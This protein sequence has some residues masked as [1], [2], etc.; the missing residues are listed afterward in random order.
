MH[1]FPCKE[2]ASSVPTVTDPLTAAGGNRLMILCGLWNQSRHFFP[3]MPSPQ[4]RF[5]E[6]A[7]AAVVNRERSTADPMSAI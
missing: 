5:D 4:T 3:L 6:N 7:N 1:R 2:A